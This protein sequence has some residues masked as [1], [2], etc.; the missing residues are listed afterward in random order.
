M[1]LFDSSLLGVLTSR[2][3]M[4]PGVPVLSGFLAAGKTTRMRNLM[5]SP[6]GLRVAI[7]V[8]DLNELN[9]DA[10]LL[11]EVLP[12]AAANGIQARVALGNGC[13]CCTIK[14]AL[15]DAIVELAT[16]GEFDHILIEGSGVAEP[17]PIADLFFAANA[18]GPRIEEVATL[19]ALITV[20]DAAA[21]LRSWQEQST[22]SPA[23]EGG[24]RPLFALMV[25]QV[26]CADVIL[27][28]KVD[29]VTPGELGAVT[30]QVQGLNSRAQLFETEEARLAP[31]VWPGPRRFDCVETRR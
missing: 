4:R 29:L 16:S 1:R 25:E 13:M 17:R 11:D 5:Q 14:D 2:P 26:E 31:G 20:V 12:E 19:H 3:E 28:N 8:N 30:V 9:I 21:W 27:L 15:G 7:I 10:A 22:A 24:Y 23:G 18:V 6:H